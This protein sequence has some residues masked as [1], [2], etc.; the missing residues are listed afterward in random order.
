M[1]FFF[2]TPPKV[3]VGRKKTSSAAKPRATGTRLGGATTNREEPARKNFP[4]RLL[5]H[6]AGCSACPLDQE[7]R[8]SANPKMGA[9]GSPHPLLYVLGEAQTADDDLAATPVSGRSS[10]VLR[11]A[12]P[13]ALSKQVRWA[14]TVQCRP[15]GDRPPTDAEIT[16]CSSRL[17]ADI[18]ATQPLIVLGCGAVPLRWALGESKV[19]DWRGELVPIQVGSWKCWYAPMYQLEYLDWKRKD[20]KEGEA[21]LQTFRRDLVRVIELLQGKRELR[22]PWIPEGE[23]L[24]AGLHWELSWKVE[25]VEAFLAHMR[26]I[27]PKQSVDIETNGLRPYAKDSKILSIAFG[28]WDL[29]S[30]A[31][32][33]SHSQS[34]WSEKQLKQVWGLVGDHLRH[35]EIEYWAHH[36][37]FET[38]WLSMPWALGRRILFEVN[39]QDTMSQAH[40][41]GSRSLSAKS[42]DA[43][44]KAMFGV[45]EKALDDLDRANLDSTPLP[46]VL[47][48][49][50][51]DTKF[52]DMVRQLQ[53]PMIEEQE[54]E[55]A[56]RLMVS[57]VPCL[58]LAQQL[59][60]MPNTEYAEAKHVELQRQYLALEAEIQALPEV[61]ALAAENGKPF[62]SASST[63]LTVLLRDRL[64][65]REGWREVK[66]VKKYSTDEEVLSRIKHPIGKLIIEQRSLAKMDGTYVLG[67]CRP[68]QEKG[69]GKLLWADGLVHTVYNYLITTTGRLSSQDPNLQNF[70]KREH[71]EIRNCIKAPPGHKLVSIDYGQIEARVIGMASRCPVLCKALWEDYDIHMDWAK[72]LSKA[73]PS[74]L[75]KYEK[76]AKTEK[77]DPLKLFRSDV[78][79]VWTFPLFFGSVLPPVAKGLDIEE[80][81]LKPHFDE[82]WQMF[83]AVKVWQD[84]VVAI[85]RT[86]GYAQTLTGRRRYE[87][88]G[89][90]EMINSP[91]QGTASD[92][93]INGMER[94]AARAYE[95]DRWQ[96]AAR[97][98]IHDDLTFYLPEATLEEDLGE[99]VQIMCTPQFDF[100]NVP[101]TVEI[102]VGDTWGDQQDIGTV[103]ST[104]YGYPTQGA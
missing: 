13:H 4:I 33:L 27:S 21:M 59:G 24:S 28:T 89:L 3:V 90:N 67:L 35:T 70:P 45:P 30:Y 58:S 22:E 86:N 26:S 84:K 25:E 77:K 40:V 102:S 103:R 81:K 49:N 78:K 44:C 60:V 6:S 72:R 11:D 15:P 66:G 82:F 51:R 5:S 37:K 31:I 95:T 85:Y 75:R 96:L 55:Q 16:A 71:Q 99:I 94:C 98:N 104:D 88:L 63:Q 91:I 53:E 36:L 34:K 32:P 20:K 57:R 74:V 56:Y 8:G 43:R 54:Q 14:N 17:Q 29:A 65:L 52:T 38:E 23:E 7:A 61:A 19:N 69:S 76:Q 93:V 46:L 9:V 10:T 2:S 83:K 41:L 39:W 100:I 18:E 48:Y 64:R 97:M 12:L 80:R 47:R 50:A 101:I 62:N 68:T 79:N 87:P 73:F 1:G 42:L 92:I